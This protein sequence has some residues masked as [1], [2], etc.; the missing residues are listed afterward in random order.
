ML[1]TLL[2]LSKR[3]KGWRWLWERVPKGRV[4]HRAGKLGGR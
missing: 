3:D 2:F 1:M 4:V